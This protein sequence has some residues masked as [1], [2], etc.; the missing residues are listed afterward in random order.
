MPTARPPFCLAI[1][2]TIEPTAPDA[3]DTNRPPRSAVGFLVHGLARRR[4]DGGA[5][6]TLLSLDNLPSNGHTLHGLVI[7]LA[8]RVSTGLARWIE[9]ECTFPNSMVDRIVPRT[10]E[11]DL[12]AV[13]AALGVDHGLHVAAGHGLDYNNVRAVAKLPG[14]EELNIG[15]AIVARAVLVGLHTVAAVAP[16]AAVVLERDAVER[17]EQVKKRVVGRHEMALVALHRPGIGMLGVGLH[18]YGFMD[19]AFWSLTAFCV[20]ASPRP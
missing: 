11:P 13:Q 1:W 9:R 17:I 3:A 15:H 16:D 10:T 8:E 4:A 5:P 19:K 7:A 18:S 14:V 20:A 6:L 2:P 12:V